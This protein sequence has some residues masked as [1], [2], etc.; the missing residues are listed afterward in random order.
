MLIPQSGWFHN[1]F[2]RYQ[3]W[4]PV[5]D[6]SVNAIPADKTPIDYAI[7]GSYM[8]LYTI[9]PDYAGWLAKK[10]LPLPIILSSGILTASVDIWPTF[11]ALNAQAWEFDDRFTDA[12][13][14]VYPCDC[15]FNL[16]EGGVIQ[17]VLTSG[18]GWLDT[19]FKP[20]LPTPGV[21]TTLTRSYAFNLGLGTCEM[22]SAA[23]GSLSS[24]I[25][26]APIVS[27]LPLKWGSN[28]I[29]KQAQIDENSLGQT[30]GLMIRNNNV[31]AVGSI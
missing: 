11:D 29:T 9:G 2:E 24:K 28:Q 1:N 22:T 30:Y 17:S 21:W 10:T 25:T 6:K 18:A 20:G 3:D 19:E 7:D 16:A 5:N 15:N 8:T 12:A 23:L 14:N 31:S 26:K 27:A 4:I 13:G